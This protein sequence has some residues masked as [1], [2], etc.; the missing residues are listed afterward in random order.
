VYVVRKLGVPG[1]PELAL[2]AIGPG[3]VR[4]LN[5]DV[6]DAYR[7]SA[8]DIDSIAAVELAELE[9]REQAYR[10]PDAAPLTLAAGR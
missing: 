1:R 5:A 4:V 10:G 6:V 7:L 9:R 2:G 3:G 8:D